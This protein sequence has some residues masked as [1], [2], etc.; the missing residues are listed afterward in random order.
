MVLRYRYKLA[1]VRYRRTVRTYGKQV[2]IQDIIE[3]NQN[4]ETR[5]NLGAS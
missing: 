1:I 4:S 5:A 2:R 3:N